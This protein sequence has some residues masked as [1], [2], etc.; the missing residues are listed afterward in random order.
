[1]TNLPIIFFFF[2][3]RNHIVQYNV[4]FLY[5]VAYN[6]VILCEYYAHEE[7]SVRPDFT[8]AIKKKE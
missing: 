2:T 3:D 8:D 5:A 6:Y 1:M 4:L 7:I